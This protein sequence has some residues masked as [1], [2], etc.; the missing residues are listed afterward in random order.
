MHGNDKTPCFVLARLLP[1]EKPEYPAKTTY[2]LLDQKTYLP[3]RIIG[4]GWNDKLICDYQYLSVKFN[5]GL[6]DK[7]F[8]P[9]ACKI[10]PPKIKK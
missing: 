4:Y 9:E 5:A 6:T 3:L 2:I 8:T 10:E 7:H 1:N